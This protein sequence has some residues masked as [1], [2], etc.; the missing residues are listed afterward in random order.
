[1]AA[2][3]L[4]KWGLEEGKQSEFLLCFFVTIFIKKKKIPGIFRKF[5]RF[6]CLTPQPP[7]FTEFK[8]SPGRPGPPGVPLLPVGAEADITIAKVS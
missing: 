4:G 8:N 2:V 3:T 1:M 5:P 7:P 6:S